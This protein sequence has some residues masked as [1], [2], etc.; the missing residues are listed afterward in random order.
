MALGSNWTNIASG[1][2]SMNG[3]TLTFYIDAKLN[4]QSIANNTSTI[5]TRM[6]TELSAGGYMGGSGYSFSCTGCSNVSGSGVYWYSTETIGTGSV[7]VSHNDDG[8][9]TFSM[10]GTCTNT[11]LGMNISVSGSVVLPTIARASKPS[12]SA[13]SLVLDGSDSVTINTNRK[14][15]SFTHTLKIKIGSNTATFTDIGASYVFKPTPSIW[16]PYMTSSEMTA[17]VTCST[18][19]GSTK[20]GSDQTCTFKVKVDMRTYHPVVTSIVLTD[21]NSVTAAATGQAQNTFIRGVSN[22]QASVTISVSD[23]NYVELAYASINVGS[24]EIEEYS[25]SGTSATLTFVCNGIT[26]DSLL[27]TVED[28]RGIATFE[29]IDLTII[30]YEPISVKAVEVKRANNLGDPSETG[31]YLSYSVQIGCFEGSFGGSHNTFTLSYK[32]RESGSSAAYTPGTNSASYT[33]TE[34]GE[35]TTHTFA[36]L[37][38]DEFASSKQYTLI[39]TITDMFSGVELE[40]IVHEGLPVYAW[41]RDHFD[42]YGEHHLHDRSDPQ[43]Y[44]TYGI[45]SEEEKTDARLAAY[46]FITSSG[47]RAVIYIPMTMLP[48]NPRIISLLVAMR[49]VTGGYLNGSEFASATISSDTGSISINKA[50]S[51]MRLV[52]EVSGYSSINNTPIAG[53][54][55]ISYT[56]EE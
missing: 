25:L 24:Q 4:S 17:T 56:V 6:R 1:S 19:S 10:S 48:V 31:S 18:Y 35:V 20:I 29:P 49:L 26:A 52:L 23:P 43:N 9:K 32:Y 40:L 11:Y 47:T 45:S 53:E 22:L 21:T 33:S 12:V 55:R 7:T 39:F 36:G 2:F 5:G 50:Q 46:G 51:I 30:P 16:M 42:I 44:L 41:G 37:T 27:V 15:S 14:V 3:A 28:T 54:V 34:D 38:G 13:A 8:T